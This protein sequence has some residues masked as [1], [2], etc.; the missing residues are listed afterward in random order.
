MI[1]GKIMTKERA[2]QLIKDILNDAKEAQMFRGYFPCDDY[3]YYAARLTDEELKELG[4]PVPDRE[5]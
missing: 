5:E 4:M 2:I 1:G 3:T